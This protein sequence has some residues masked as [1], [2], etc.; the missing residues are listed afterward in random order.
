MVLAAV[1]QQSQSLVRVADNFATGIAG[2]IVPFIVSSDKPSRSITEPVPVHP[3][4]DS[5]FPISNVVVIH[6][7]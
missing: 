4:N 7:V 1:A 5:A 3:A 6:G 2:A